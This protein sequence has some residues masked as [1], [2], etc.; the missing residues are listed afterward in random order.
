MDSQGRSAVEPL[1][2]SPPK[3]P[4]PAGADE[5][6]RH[7]RPLLPGR[8][9]SCDTDPGVSLRCTPGYRRAPLRGEQPAVTYGR[10][11]AA[12][13]YIIPQVRWHGPCSWNRHIS[14]CIAR[15]S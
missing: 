8:C 14:Y 15:V 9:R 4:A 11:T 10:V 6:L 7:A 2:C 3:N 13:G 12:R 5:H 1:V